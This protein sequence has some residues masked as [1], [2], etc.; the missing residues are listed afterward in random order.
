MPVKVPE[1]L[2]PFVYKL[3]FEYVACFTA[4]AQRVPFLGF[5]NPLRQKVNFRQIFN[6]AQA[7]SARQEARSGEAATGTSKEARSGE[8]ATGKRQS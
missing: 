5:H 7:G 1:F 6:S 2:S 8:A 4:A 3:P